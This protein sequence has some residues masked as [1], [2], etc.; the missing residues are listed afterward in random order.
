MPPC[1]LPAVPETP[2]FLDA[3]AVEAA[4][5]FRPLIE[6][7]GEAFVTAATPPVRHHHAVPRSGSDPAIL[8]IMPA[9]QPDAV[10]GVKLVHV[11]SGNEAKGLPSVQGLYVLFDGPT[12][13]PLAVMDGTRLT[14]RRTAAASALAASHLAR[15]DAATLLMLGCGA[16]APHLIAAHRTVRPIQRVLLWNRTPQRAAALA[17]DL[18]AQGV[19]AVAVAEIDPA[20][21][22]ADIV[23]CATMS[24]EPLVRGTAVRAGTHVDLVGAYTPAMRESDGELL[25]RAEVFVDTFDG[26][27]AEAGDVLQAI[28][29]GHL[30]REAIEGDLAALCRGSHPGRSS[31]ASIT[32][33]KSVGSALE[34]L[35]AARLVHERAG[36]IA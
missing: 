2:I 32:V 28:A 6:A 34:D 36:A 3:A 12:G 17:R 27:E 26:A 18:E 4:L 23:S 5:P 13:T 33:F 19:D 14:V 35:V 24:R 31:A 20:L 16:M 30:T 11:A 15:A 1:Q 22:E 25:A 10:T 8:L 7:L 21:A 29:E 9:W